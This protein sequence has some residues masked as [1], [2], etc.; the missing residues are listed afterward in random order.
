MKTDRLKDGVVGL[1][2]G[3]HH[4]PVCAAL[5]DVQLKARRRGRRCILTAGIQ[6]ANTTLANKTNP[7]YTVNRAADLQR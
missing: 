7:A 5:P 2:M 1:G 3:R 4:A 6:S